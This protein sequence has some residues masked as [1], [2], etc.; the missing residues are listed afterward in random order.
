MNTEY[1]SLGEFFG[2]WPSLAI[3]ILLMWGFVLILRSGGTN[4]DDYDGY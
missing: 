2:L 4:P 1:V 3:I